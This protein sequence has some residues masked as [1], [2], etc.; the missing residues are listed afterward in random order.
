M[1][2]IGIEAIL[3]VLLGVIFLT[4]ALPKLRHPRGFVLAVLEYRV[5]PRASVGF[6][7]V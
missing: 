4:S 3:S 1:S 7:R 5:L 6:M 2:I